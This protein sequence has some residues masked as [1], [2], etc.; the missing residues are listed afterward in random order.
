MCNY[1]NHIKRKMMEHI[2]AWALILDL[3]YS[4][5]LT[6]MWIWAQNSFSSYFWVIFWLQCL[7][8]FWTFRS[9]KT[10]V[11]LYILHWET[12][13]DKW[14]IFLNRA[15]YLTI[16]TSLHF[17]NTYPLHNG[18]YVISNSNENN[19]LDVANLLFVTS[20]AAMIKT[21]NSLLLFILANFF[22]LHFKNL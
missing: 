4:G 3:G 15:C 17:W 8:K 14:L 20:N 2:L 1:I 5:T 9:S 10:K 22:R 21:C 16:T 19:K 6:I 18:K 7:A 12:E 11:Q 13:H